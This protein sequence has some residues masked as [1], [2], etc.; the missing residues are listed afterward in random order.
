MSKVKINSKQTITFHIKLVKTTRKI[1]TI[2]R[3]VHCNYLEDVIYWIDIYRKSAKNKHN[4]H[5]EIEGYA[6]YK[7]SPSME[8]CTAHIPCVQSK[9][10][11]NI[12]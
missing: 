3:E 9:E 7:Y 6:L 4:H 11:I 10:D 2:E 12:I 8:C 1:K 5:I